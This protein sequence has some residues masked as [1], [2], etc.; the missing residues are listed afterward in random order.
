MKPTPTDIAHAVAYTLPGLLL[1]AFA[2]AL[3]ATGR[4]AAAYPGA[5][6]WARRYYRFSLALISL[7]GAGLL[8]VGGAFAA[9]VLRL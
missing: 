3:R 4:R 2:A 8:V 5:P 1:L 7:V 9:A 6:R